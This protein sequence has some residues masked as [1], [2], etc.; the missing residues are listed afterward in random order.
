V[1]SATYR[2]L[3]RTPG[4]AAFFLSSTAGRVGVAMTS[5]GVVWLV[6]D[7]TGSYAKAG[8]V[9]ACLAVAE[10]LA[11]PQLAWL[12][13]RR[14]QRRVLPAILLAH[15][16]AV[17]TLLVL[18]QA[19]AAT[20]LLAA[21]GFLVGAS[22]PQLGALSAA[23]WS[24]LLRTTAPE[25]LPTAFALEAASNGA[26][27]LIG[28]AVVSVIAAIVPALGTTLAGA[29]VVGGGSVLV[30]QRRTEPP[31]VSGRAP[32][33]T[34]LSPGFIAL[35]GVN[36]TIGAFFGASPI[37]VTAFATA[38]GAPGSAAILFMVSN[39][40]GLLAC[41]LYGLRRWTTAARVQLP[42]AGV[43]L[44]LGSLP[45]LVAASP[46]QLGIGVT[47]AGTA[48]AILLVLC[49]TLTESM[50][51]PAALT[52][53]FTWLGA[54]GAAG[55]AA[56]AAITGQAVDAVGARGGLVVAVVAAVAAAVI[57]G[58]AGRALRVGSIGRVA[59]DDVSAAWVSALGAT[60]ADRE[61]AEARLHD[62]L[63]RIARSE[64]N[65]RSGRLRVTGAEM[66]DIA[67]QAAA[68]AMIAVLA[69]LP[70]FRG[71]SRFT[72]WAYKFVMFE[73]SA[74]IGRHFWQRPAVSM[75]AQD[76]ERLPDAFGF[77]PEQETEWRDLI[78]ALRK[79]IA[80]E[81]TD[82]QR[83]VFAALVLDGVPLDALVIEL[84]TNRNAVYKTLFDARRKVRA[85]LVAHGY[86]D[87][88]KV[89]RS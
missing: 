82:R 60:G 79:V 20:G 2:S 23:R 32:R 52:R 81:L 45:M 8:L 58:F 28:P 39:G 74:K 64:V 51:H 21:G 46:A 71:D 25:A 5:L 85:A 76:W 19:R 87:G 70:T 1:A 69:K 61:P 27:Y 29:L 86:L 44:G 7:A 35:A 30:A 40:A 68:D 22:I 41:W 73:V 62:L 50:V 9:A 65:R 67:Y 55:S 54:A 43:A 24:A 11:A 37:A 17:I 75:D 16:A 6:H 53:A 66:D 48:I 78:A 4:A 80:E 38:H 57:G 59:L 89:S 10:G 84:G 56:S 31:T 26:A 14:G 15:A 77:R 36:L 72:T 47:L 34:L 33:S 88:D 49:A 13:D 3:L 42:V 18:A 12:I 63:L 83:R